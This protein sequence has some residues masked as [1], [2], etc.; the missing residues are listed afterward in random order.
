MH[1]EPIDHGQPEQGMRRQQGADHDGRDGR[2][3][4]GETDGGAEQQ[5]QRGRDE[6]EGDRAFAGAAEQGEID[7]QAGKEHQQQLAQFRQEVRDRAIRAEEAEDMGADDDP[8]EQQSHGGGDMRTAAQPRN[9]DE[10][11]QR[12]SEPSECR[13]VQDVMSDEVGDVRNQCPLRLG[14]R[15]MVL[16]D[17]QGGP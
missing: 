5:W 1:P 8:A 7:F 10:H 16:S 2:V 6:T 9:E 17:N 4:E 11:D 3:A 13:E 15:D 12:Q 14:S